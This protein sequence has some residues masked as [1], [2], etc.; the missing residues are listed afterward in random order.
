MLKAFSPGATVFLN[1][2]RKVQ[3]AS[4]DRSGSCSL[5][6]PRPV[7]Y[8]LGQVNFL[9]YFSHA[10]FFTNCRIGSFLA[11]FA[12]RHILSL[13]LQIIMINK[14]VKFPYQITIPWRTRYLSVQITSHLNIPHSS[15][16]GPT[17]WWDSYS[18]SLSCFAT[19]RCGCTLCIG[20]RKRPSA[21]TSWRN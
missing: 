17:R 11:F 21:T 19:P 18:A 1:T 16:I 15:R 3:V 2:W 6:W 13:F 9:T 8:V 20:Q 5:V 12:I 14:K 10:F 7:Q 4:F